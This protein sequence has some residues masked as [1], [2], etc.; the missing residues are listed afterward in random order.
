MIPRC[1][2][3]G[4]YVEKVT[5]QRYDFKR[6]FNHALGWWVILVSPSPDEGSWVRYDDLATVVERLGQVTAERDI[7]LAAMRTSE[8]YRAADAASHIDDQ[9]ATLKRA[10]AAEAERDRLR[11]YARHRAECA[12][13][14]WEHGPGVMHTP[15]PACT[16]GLSDLLAR[17]DGTR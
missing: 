15:R 12:I 11:E 9:W 17:K 1:H 4:T 6:E 16:C 5:I 13:T 3:S 7:A 14:D 8:R 10:E 2:G